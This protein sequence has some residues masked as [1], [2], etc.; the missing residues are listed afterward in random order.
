MTEHRATSR[1]DHQEWAIHALVCLLLSVV[2]TQRVWPAGN[3]FIL[4]ETA[5]MDLPGTAW[6]YWWTGHSIGQGL[7]PFEGSWNYF[8]I[9]V[10]SLAQYNLLDALL[11]SPLFQLLNPVLAYNL[12]VVLFLTTTGL[13]LTWLCRVAG[14]SHFGARLAGAGIICSSFLAYEIS[15][16]R[17]SQ[18]LLIFWFGA[19]SGVLQI[20]QG[21][22]TSRTVIWTG[23]LASATSLVYWYNGLFLGLAGLVLIATHRRSFPRKA[24]L[25][26]LGAATVALLVCTPFLVVLIQEFESLPGVQG[27]AMEPWMANL[28][29]ARGEFGLANTIH[30]SHWPL[31]PLWPEEHLLGKPVSITMMLLAAWTVF[32]RSTGWI[33][34]TSLAVVG[35]VLTLGPYLRLTGSEETTSIPLPYLLLY[36]WVPF[37]NRFWWPQR[38]ELLFLTGLFVLAALHIEPIRKKW[39]PLPWLILALMMT[40]STVRSPYLPFGA[41]EAPRGQDGFY[42]D[43]DGALLTTPVANHYDSSRHLIWLQLLH[44]QPILGGDGDHIPTHRPPGYDAYISERKVLTAL[45]ELGT[46]QFKGIQ[47]QPEDVTALLNDGF[48]YA[49]VD[50]VAYW[51]G[52]RKQWAHT[53]SEFFTQLWGEPIRRLEDAAIWRIR[54]IERPQQLQVSFKP[55]PRGHRAK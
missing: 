55:S 28:D 9:G 50:P 42:K 24:W 51:P 47:V 20:C 4:G 40:E 13:A 54:P 52:L 36:D 6:L 39:R 22:G 29:L 46:G 11:A 15:E 21:K 48:L 31:W 5:P 44:K 18:I 10:D 41:E 14:A 12:T 30:R 32:K 53:Y 37:F 35:W 8:P 25:Q 1:V 27:R 45:S 49:V 2:L 26:L 43:L 3:Q 23:M 38:L 7:N 19:L 34:W 17:L 16:G 33:T